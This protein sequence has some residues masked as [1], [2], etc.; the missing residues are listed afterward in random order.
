M[1]GNG[2]YLTIVVAA[3]NDRCCWKQTYEAF[4]AR[5]AAEANGSRSVG[6]DRAPCAKKTSNERDEW[7]AP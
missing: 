4:A 2:T 7:C 5:S 3:A 6:D 1:T